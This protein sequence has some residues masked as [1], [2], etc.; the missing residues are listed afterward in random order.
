MD[1]QPP[2][3]RGA[4][5]FSDVDNK[6]WLVWDSKPAS[7]LCFEIVAYKVPRNRWD[8]VIEGGDVP[9]LGH[10]RFV[11]R[12]QKRAALDPAK[13]RVGGQMSPLALAR[14]EQQMRLAAASQAAEEGTM[15]HA[16]L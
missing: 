2:L 9:G 16:R 8:Y 13:V 11:V 7:P 6:A 15:I 5:L 12:A 10:R 4:V 1:Q 3:R 14:L